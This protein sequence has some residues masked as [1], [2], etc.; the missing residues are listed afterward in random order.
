MDV[1]LVNFQKTHRKDRHDS[2]GGVI[3]YVK[4]TIPCKRREDLEIE[5]LES[6]WLELKLK[7]K[8][9]ILAYFTGLQILIKQS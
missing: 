5:G 9:T 8:V 2:Y 6:I 7:N 1:S 3:V 4:D